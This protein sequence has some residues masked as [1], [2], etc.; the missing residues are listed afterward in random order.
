M[1]IPID[2]IGNPFA[3][4]ARSVCS[5]VEPK[6][7]PSGHPTRSIS[8]SSTKVSGLMSSQLYANKTSVAPPVCQEI[9]FSTTITSIPIKSVA[10]HINHNINDYGLTSQVHF[11]RLIK[12]VGFFYLNFHFYTFELFKVTTSLKRLK[13]L[14]FS[15]KRTQIRK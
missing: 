10:L 13:V 7:C 4:S 3:R 6:I 2:A 12:G 8:T 9:Y 14:F 1:L 11:Q 15:A 5:E